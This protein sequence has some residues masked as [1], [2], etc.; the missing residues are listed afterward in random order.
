MRERATSWSCSMM[1][2]CFRKASAPIF[3]FICTPGQYSVLSGGRFKK[4][5][6]IDGL[7]HLLLIRDEGSASPDV[8]V[9]VRFRK[10]FNHF[11][12]FFDEIVEKTV[13]YLRVLCHKC[14]A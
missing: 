2:L 14:S 8:Q 3:V 4:E 13:L 1:E 9:G 6:F 10:R 12:T 7:S 11:E 5:V